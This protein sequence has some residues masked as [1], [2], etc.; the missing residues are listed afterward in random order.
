MSPTS[1]RRRKIA[2]LLF[3]GVPPLNVRT[4]AVTIPSRDLLTILPLTT[5]ITPRPQNDGGWRSFASSPLFRTS[6]FPSSTRAPPSTS[7][8]DKA[9]GEPAPYA[10]GRYDL[11]DLGQ[12]GFRG[13][14]T[15]IS[16]DN[17]K[18]NEGDIR[19]ESS[20]YVW[21]NGRRELDEN[22]DNEEDYYGPRY[23]YGGRNED[24]ALASG[25]K[26][27]TR[28]PPPPK[29][30]NRSFAFYRRDENPE[31]DHFVESYSTARRKTFSS[32]Y[33]SDRDGFFE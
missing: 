18:D 30:S 13:S 31:K 6:K 17:A 32:D 29:T 12:R 1:H 7:F 33:D 25:P 28:G 16:G 19:D 21:R 27:L 11:D 3:T 8:D 5:R 15:R 4:S 24:S 26:S 23:R 2:H 20:P 22:G 14:S 9:F 10:S